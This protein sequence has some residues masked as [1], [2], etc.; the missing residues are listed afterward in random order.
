MRRVFALLL[1]CFVLSAGPV[2]AETLSYYGVLSDALSQ[3]YDIRLAR[4]DVNL[5]QNEIRNSL[6]DYLPTLRGQANMEYMRDLTSGQT[7]VAV[8]GTTT[9][10]N[11]TRFQ[12][13]IYLS[14]NYTVIDFGVR[15]HQ[16]G[17]ARHRRS[18][19]IAAVHQSRRDLKIQVIDT[20]AEALLNYR[21]LK[22]KERVLDIEREL[23]DMRKRL[24]DAGRVSRVEVAEEALALARTFDEIHEAKQGL[25]AALRALSTYTHKEYL[26]DN[27]DVQ[28]FP[29]ERATE[30]VTFVVENMPEYRLYQSQIEAKKRELQAVRRQRLPQ[31][32]I[33]TNFYMYGFDQNDW[34][35]A[36]GNFKGRTIAFGIG[37]A[38]PIFDGFKNR[39]ECE[40][41]QLE[42]SRLEIE[43]DK[44][45][46]KLQ[47]KHARL[48]TSAKLLNKQLE[49]KDGV[50]SQV[51]QK[52]VMVRRLTDTQIAQRTDYLT[53]QS[54]LI[55]DE[56]ERDRTRVQELAS[57]KKLH[58][59]SEG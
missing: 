37:A 27:I 44:T 47:D 26:P 23:Y 54:R 33:Y 56:L 13:A 16:L 22:A 2:R 52:V 57:C 24:Y 31:F 34:V 43:R 7:P 41:K 29:E 28:L 3:S 19:A 36:L 12:N 18:A 46:W 50:L 5:T 58:V 21:A 11:A 55:E 14:A 48:S 10:P 42:I 6:T 1:F 8:V 49:L 38:L 4:A 53:Q 35:R 45:L 30:P 39:V 51:T 59:L 25:I 9:I 15:G 20:Y 17:A 40:R 32:S